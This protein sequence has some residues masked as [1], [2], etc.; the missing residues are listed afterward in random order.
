MRM[1]GNP[2]LVLLDVTAISGGVQLGM[3]VDLHNFT[4]RVQMFIEKH[5]TATIG[6]YSMVNLWAEDLIEDLKTL[7]PDAH[8]EQCDPGKVIAFVR[9]YIG[10]TPC[11][12]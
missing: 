3:G 1:E 7:V 9:K 11:T 12:T 4:R 10:G 2:D 8:V 5:N 6:I